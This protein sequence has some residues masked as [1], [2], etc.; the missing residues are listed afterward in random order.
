VEPYRNLDDET[1][2]YSSHFKALAAIVNQDQAQLSEVNQSGK[3]RLLM[4]KNVSKSSVATWIRILPSPLFCHRSLA[5]PLTGRAAQPPEF[6][7]RDVVGLTWS[8]RAIP[9]QQ[10]SRTEP[11][12]D[13][14][15]VLHFNKLAQL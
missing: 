4:F 14:Q 8:P 11:Q 5:S 15:T 12:P 13:I 1:I 2:T 9:P 7:P 10:V 3:L 6:S